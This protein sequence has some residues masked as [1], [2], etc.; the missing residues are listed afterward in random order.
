MY[1][2]GQPQELWWGMGHGERLTNKVKSG[3]LLDVVV[4]KCSSI[5]KLLSSEN[6]TL[7]IGRDALL[8]LDLGLDHID[9]VRGLHLEGD[10]E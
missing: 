9:G 5:L 1:A 3:L 10:C 6:E 7:L 2:M 4:R 8:V